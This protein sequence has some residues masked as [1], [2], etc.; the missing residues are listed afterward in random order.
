MDHKVSL[1]APTHQP[2]RVRERGVRRF[3][4][5]KLAQRFLSVHAAVYNLFTLSRH[6]VSAGNYRM[7]RA[8]AMWSWRQVVEHLIA[9]RVR[10]YLTILNRSGYLWRLSERKF[11]SDLNIQSTPLARHLLNMTCTFLS[12]VLRASSGL[13]SPVAAWRNIS[14]MIQDPNTSEMPALT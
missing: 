5:M 9:C 7:L 4:T 6:L 3:K 12:A 11:N 2:T 10:R 14:G 13:I 1:T 8:G